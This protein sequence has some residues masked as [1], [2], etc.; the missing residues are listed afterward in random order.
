MRSRTLIASVSRFMLGS[1]A[2]IGVVVFGGFFALRSI[3]VGEAERQT[4]EQVRV[5]SRLVELAGLSDGVLRE[6]PAAL[7]RLDRL[8]RSEI[9]S[10]SV[11][12]VKLWS[13]DGQILYSDERRLIGRR[14]GLTHDEMRLFGSGGADAE[15]SDLAKPENR[16]ERA[17]RKLLEAHTPIRTP[18]GAPVLFEIYRRF[19]SVDASASQL[20]GALAP[21]LLLAF[22]VLLVFQAP[23]AWSMA[24]RLQRG[25][26]EREQLLANAIAASTQERERI[27]AD[28]HDGVVQDLAGVAFGLAPVA[29][30]AARSGADDVAQA[31]RRAIERLRQ[32]VRGLRSLLVEIDPPSLASTG[33]EPALDD[34][35]S[36]LEA[37]GIATSLEVDGRATAAS[38]NDPLI[39]RVAREAL[40]NVQAHADATS[41]RLEV[42]GADHG[43]RSLVVRD[44]GRGFAP[45]DRARRGEEGHMGLHLLEA[46]AEQAG[47]R[48]AVRSEPGHGTSVEL[49]VPSK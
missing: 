41:V 33:L 44:D 19:E 40:R 43:T 3:A 29:D 13:R 14:Y 25:H 37:A 23:L 2:A 15:L 6:Q 20:L 42:S 1:L 34:L 22:A 27:A 39:Y 38:A 4:R 32:G 49:E 36:P 18:G 9:L 12:R 7:S 21:P 48:L 31:V 8:V 11:V 5:Q 17:E 10:P 45:D 46:L 24:R 47:G 35:L 30:E 26:D 28:L 16:F